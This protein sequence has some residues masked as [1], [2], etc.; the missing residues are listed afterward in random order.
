MRG[1]QAS[2]PSPRVGRVAGAVAVL[3]ALVAGVILL[4]V[5]TGDDPKDEVEEVTLAFGAAEGPE[6]CQYLSAEALEQ[7]GG[8]EGCDFAFRGAPAAEF[9]IQ[10]EIDVQ[11]DTATAQVLNTESETL[12]DLGY[13]QEEDGWKVSN[14]PGLEQIVPTEP[15]SPPPTAPPDETETTDTDATTETTETEETTVTEGTTETEGRG[16]GGWGGANGSRR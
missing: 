8:T 7:I 15:Q 1:R 3:L 12:I 13:V 2:G 14:F 5:L 9:E 16:G 10:G 11:G 4:I 6:S